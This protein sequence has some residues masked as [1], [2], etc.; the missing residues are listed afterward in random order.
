MRLIRLYVKNNGILKNFVLDFPQKPD[1]NISV[2]IGENGSGK[3]TVL[4][5]ITKIFSWF[6]NNEKPTFEFELEYQVRL[7][8]KIMDSSTW[9]EFKT[10]YIWVKLF[11]NKD[12]VDIECNI[13]ETVLNEL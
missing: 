3:T 9:S 12:I 13:A 1:N 11:S 4:E 10:D 6:V 2:F 5:S 8:D 7:E